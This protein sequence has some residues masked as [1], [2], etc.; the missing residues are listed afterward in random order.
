MSGFAPAGLQG[1]S[2][3]RGSSADIGMISREPYLVEL[4]RFVDAPKKKN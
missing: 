3:Y 4:F 2:G 1:Y